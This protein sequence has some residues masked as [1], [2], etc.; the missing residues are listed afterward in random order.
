MLG[1]Q[2]VQ[3]SKNENSSAH[4]KLVFWTGDVTLWDIEQPCLYDIKTE[5]WIGKDK[6]DEKVVTYGYRKARFKKE[7]DF[8]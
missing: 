2:L 1:E 3:K 5:L 4:T 7:A 6:V 8:T